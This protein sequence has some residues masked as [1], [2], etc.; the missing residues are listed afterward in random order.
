LEAIAL[1][2]SEALDNLAQL[3]PGPLGRL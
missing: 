2:L 1:D 3:L